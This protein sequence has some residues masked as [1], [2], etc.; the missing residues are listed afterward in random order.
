MMTPDTH[1]RRGRARW[2]PFAIAAI[3]AVAHAESRLVDTRVEQVTVERPSY[4]FLRFNEDWSV[5]RNRPEDGASDPWDDITY[6]PLNDAGDI[7]LG[8]D[9]HTRAR[10]EHFQDFGF[11]ASAEGN[12]TYLLWRRR[13]HADLHVGENL[14][15]HVE[16]KSALATDREL[17]GGNRPVDVETLDLEQA[18]ADIRVPCDD[19]SITICPG[20]QQLLFRKQR[21][22][23]PLPWGNSL[24]RWD[25]VSMLYES[26][27]INAHAL[28]THFAPM[29]KY[30]VNQPDAQ[31]VF[32]SAYATKP[33]SGRSRGF[34]VYFRGLHR[35]DAAI[36]NG[37]SGMEDRYTIGSRIF[38]TLVDSPVDYDVESADQFGE[39][40]DGDVD[41]YMVGSRIGYRLKNIQG[42][43]RLRIGVDYGSGDDAPGGDVGTFNQLFPLGYAFLG[44]L[45]LIGR[46]NILDI[47]FGLDTTP[48]DRTT[49]GATL[50]LF[51]RA[52]DQDAVY[53]ASGGV[54]R[55]GALGGSREVG[56]EI[57]LTIQ[58]RF[59][60]H[61]SALLGDAHF[62]AGEYIE[63]TGPIQ[64][65]EVVYLQ[66]QYTF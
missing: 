45:D 64:D 3:T 47:S 44:H 33:S 13:L 51:Y 20:R 62:F 12:D 48:I 27:S 14:R 49:F 8:F 31:T 22:V 9:G 61:F 56:Q 41:A 42:S 63:Q 30:D 36:L 39:V 17:P 18:F 54:L 25:G 4:T 24:R 55:S 6:I 32:F 26:S 65:T 29:L 15:F 1:R 21:L 16:G 38:G 52:S 37:T 46:Q 40:G 5:M 53:N 50:H 19:Q 23:S 34:D 59:D 2:M 43:P 60:R 11:G 28:W 66:V 10:L 35:G 7:W 58:H 57:D